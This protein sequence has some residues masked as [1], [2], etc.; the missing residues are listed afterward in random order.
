MRL[1]FIKTSTF[2]SFLGIVLLIFCHTTTFA[3][4]KY[5]PNHPLTSVFSKEDTLPAKNGWIDSITSKR[6]IRQQLLKFAGRSDT[7]DAALK[8]SS[9]KPFLP[10]N[11]KIIRTIVFLQ[12]SVFGIEIDTVKNFSERVKNFL[13]PLHSSTKRSILQQSLFF[14]KFDRLDP[15]KMSDNERYIR[16]LPF[17]HDARI[18]VDLTESCTDS[19]DVL[20][21]TR[22]VF[23]LGVS[24]GYSNSQNIKLSVFNANLGG[25]G[26][27]LQFAVQWNTVRNPTWGTAAFYSKSNISGSFVDATIG[28]SHLNDQGQ[29]DTGV[30]ENTYYIRLNRPLY[31]SKA[32]FTGGFNYNYNNSMNINSLPIDQFRNYNYR[33]FDIWGGWAFKF[34]SHNQRDSLNLKRKAITAKYYQRNFGE[35]PRQPQFALDPNYN[36]WRYNL[37]QFILFKQDYYKGRFIYGFGR[38]EDVPYG[39]TLTFTGGIEERLNRKR[40]Y[41]AAEFENLKVF[42]KGNFLYNYIGVGGFFYKGWEDGVI[43]ARTEYYSTLM[44]LGKFRLRQISSLS[45]I[46]CVDPAIYKPVNINQENGIMGLYSTRINNYQRLNIRTESSIFT[47]YSL[48]D[49]KINFFGLFQLSQIGRNDELVLA[50]KFY[51]V[52]GAGIRIRNENLVLR[53]LKIGV[54]FYPF[55]PNEV[56]N[57][58]FDLNTEIPFHFR[59]TAIREPS[60]IPFN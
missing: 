33:S 46:D 3:Q 47:P 9:V 26:Q 4:G 58:V 30:Y 22:D 45:Y 50:Q 8:E 11:E 32:H 18:F 21:T 12:V 53:T 27:R 40:I 59:T 54:Y 7:G 60:F 39:Y 29:I 42:R 2:C 1:F 17:I 16:D 13:E 25:R 49:F 14:K 56:N 36:N 28:Y 15:V 10:F 20:V 48:L 41:E 6:F 51:S 19:V 34:G 35:M 38:T 31:S 24:L 57:V 43:S 5:N 55:A 37:Y 52:I 44:K 23:G